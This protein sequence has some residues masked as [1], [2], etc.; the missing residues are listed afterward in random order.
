LVGP[1]ALQLLHKDD[2]DDDDDDDDNEDNNNN[3]DVTCV[4][5]RTCTQE[6]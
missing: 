5:T 3:N 4:S 2:G 1:S 6:T